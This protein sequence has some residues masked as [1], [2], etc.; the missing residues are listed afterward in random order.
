MI[1][2]YCVMDSSD[3]EI[4]FDHHGICNHCK[5]AK[6]LLLLR[7]I[8]GIQGRFELNKVLD[9][10]KTDSSNLE[11]DGIIGLSGGVDSCFLLHILVKEFNLRILAVHVNSGWNSEIAENNIELL[12]KKLNVDLY[13]YVVDW[14][15]MRDLQL[16]YLKSGLINQDVPQDHLF[17]TILHQI[18]LYHMIF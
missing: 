11:Y 17:Y 10:V 1:C 14:E 4:V 13:T 18:T 15:E 6:K 16:A 5:D 9:T 3:P 7:N 12:V 8:G 2:N